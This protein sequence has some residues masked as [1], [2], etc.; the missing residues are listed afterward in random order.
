MK[1][2][3]LSECSFRGIALV[4]NEK[5]IKIYPYMAKRHILTETEENKRDNLIVIDNQ[6]LCF[7]PKPI[8]DK[9]WVKSEIK[10]NQE[11]VLKML[12]EFVNI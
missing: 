8:F 5:A 6:H 4:T 9:M 12:R 3:D 11:S 7:V 1:S 10:K 2:P